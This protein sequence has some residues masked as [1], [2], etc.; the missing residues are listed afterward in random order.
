MD[1][2]NDIPNIDVDYEE[3]W[4]KDWARIEKEIKEAFAGLR[5]SLEELNAVLAA[6]P[7]S[8]QD[9]ESTDAVIE[10]EIK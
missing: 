6:P 4:R 7:Y 8:V 9:E 5:E 2:L 1:N 10:K 3:E